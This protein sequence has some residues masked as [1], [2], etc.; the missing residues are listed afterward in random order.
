MNAIQ[1]VNVYKSYG[2]V[3][4]IR[5]LNLDIPKGLRLVLLGPSGCGK[6]TILRM[7]AGLES[8]T[9]GDLLMSGERVN[10]IEPGDRNVSMVFQNYALY[11][12]MTIED[13]ILF[14]MQVAKIDK[15]EQQERLFWALDILKLT[16]Y[17]KRY[18]KELSGGQR[19]RVA[20]CR[21]LVKKAPYLLL[22]E[23]LS[24]LDAQLRTDARAELVKIHEVYN[25]TFVYVTHDQVEAMTIGHKIAILDKSIIQQLDTPDNI[26]NKPKNVFV[27]RFIGSPSMNVMKVLIEGDSLIFDGTPIK[28]PAN[29]RELIGNRT[30]VKI[31]IRPEHIAIGH[32]QGEKLLVPTFVEN[33]GNRKCIS[34]KLENNTLMV[35]TEP[36]YSVASET[37][38]NIPWRDV[39][40]FDC[41]T[42]ENIGYPEK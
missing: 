22:D 17:V 25:P 1:F 33:H 38:M 34:F 8:I 18:P 12:H 4:V 35:T 30:K 2:Q 24:N 5:D 32:S 19:Q 39:H 23:P 15:K 13:N 20:L 14:G 29:W 21:A 37:Y 7:I 28:I 6:T 3:E 16:P 9:S 10:D 41:E 40:F 27:G 36:D 11:P 26:Y 31:G 42:E